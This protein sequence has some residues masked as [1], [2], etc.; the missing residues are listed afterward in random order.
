MSIVDITEEIVSDIDVHAEFNKDGMRISVYVDEAEITEHVDYDD[1][2]Y[3]MVQDMDKYPPEVL[4]WIR[5]GL[6][7]M[8]DILEEAEDDRE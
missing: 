1:M 7:C 4:K 6:A 3:M 5:S 8:L 2:A